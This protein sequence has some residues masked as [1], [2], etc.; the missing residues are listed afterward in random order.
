MSFIEEL[1]ELLSKH[2]AI[3]Q[4]AQQLIEHWDEHND[5][6]NCHVCHLVESVIISFPGGRCTM[7]VVPH[8]ATYESREYDRGKTYNSILKLEGCEELKE[9]YELGVFWLSDNLKL[10]VEMAHT[11]NIGDDVLSPSEFSYC[12]YCGAIIEAKLK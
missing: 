2:D 9:Y 4:S 10:E 7:S 1:E 12:P 11:N 5:A 3:E 6:R 8:I